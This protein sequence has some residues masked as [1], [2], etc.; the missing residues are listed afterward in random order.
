MS[1]QIHHPRHPEQEDVCK[2]P[3]AW[4]NE[5]CLIERQQRHGPKNAPNRH[6]ESDRTD[7]ERLGIPRPEQVWRGDHNR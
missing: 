6:P 1:D 7:Y 2:S 3:T 4:V 5:I